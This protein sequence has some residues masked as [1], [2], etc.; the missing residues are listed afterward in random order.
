MN[1]Q[2]LEYF[3][4]AAEAGNITQAAQQ[5]QISQQALS[6]HIQRLEKEL[7]C[8][9]FDR[10]QG[11]ELTFSGRKFKEAAEQMLDIQSQTMNLLNDIS[12]NARGEV[13]IGISYTRGQALLP[14]LLPEFIKK[15]PLAELSVLE[16]SSSL[17]EKHLEHGDI[18]ILIGFA[19]FMFDGAEYYHL[20]QEH[21]YLVI[22]N[23]LL[24]EHFPT[25]EKAGQTLNE[26]RSSHDLTLFRDFPFVLLKKGDRIRTIADNAFRDA[27]FQPR[28]K[29]ETQ[30]T[31]TAVALASE[32]LGVTICP[33]FYLSNAYIASGGRDSYIRSRITFCP[34]FD[35]SRSDVIAIG[36]NKN[37]YLSRMA[38]DFIQ[39]SIDRL[40]DQPAFPLA[41]PADS[42]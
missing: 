27:G 39:M 32:G 1:F 19:P 7:G 38:S 9:L 26:F 37:R 29:L 42:E 3:L 11:L 21:L 33:E 20:M 22:P 35:Q 34:L 4:A 17:L 6:G 24:L 12:L 25:A 40:R 36:Y 16:D 13:R 14:L 5:L 15:Y 31:Q 2:N 18:D 28:I 10:R 30:N 41:V 8:I 23:E